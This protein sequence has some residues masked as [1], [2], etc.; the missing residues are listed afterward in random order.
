MKSFTT[1]LTEEHQFSNVQAQ[2]YGKVADEIVAFGKSLSDEEIYVNEDQNIPGR[3]SE[4]HVTLLYGIHGTDAR[5]TYELLTGK[6]RIEVTLGKLS[7]FDTAPTHDVLKVSVVDADGLRKLHNRIKENIPCTLTH[8]DYVPHV[9]VAYMK[10]GTAA[11]Y[12]GDERFLGRVVIIDRLF[13]SSRG[14]KK[15]YISL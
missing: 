14:G 2:L 15:V 4:S 7:M 11:K 13:F 5:P 9:T 1:F 6:G 12:V 8:P 3:E 10:K